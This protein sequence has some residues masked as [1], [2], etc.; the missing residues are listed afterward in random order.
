MPYKKKVFTK[1][2][3]VDGKPYWVRG[4]TDEEAT[5][6][7]K[8]K[9]AAIEAGERVVTGNSTVA[10]WADEWMRTYK[11][12]VVNPALYR[13]M[14]GQIKNYILPLIGKR[15]VRSIKPKDLQAVIN[16]VANQGKSDSLIRAIRDILNGMFREA[17]ANDM[18]KNYPAG[19]LIKTPAGKKKMK[20]RSLTDVERKLLLEVAKTH[21]GGP[22]CLIM[23]YAGLRPAEVA[24]LTWADVDLENRKIR[25]TNAIKADGTVGPPKTEAGIR[26]VPISDEL[27][28]V[29]KPLKGKARDLV[30]T[31]TR[32]ERYNHTSIRRMWDYVRNAM[33]LAA[34]CKSYYNRA[35]PPLVVGDDCQL[36]CLRHTYC[37]DLQAAGVPINVAKEL[38]GHAK[39]ST[40]SEI[41][42][43]SSDAA[44]E[45]AA[46]KINDF[47]KTMV[48]PTV[49][50]GHADAEK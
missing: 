38:M 43:H 6:K 35:V 48:A 5:A 11:A 29:L 28:A 16:D 26:T 50:P 46:S 31:N 24:A 20:R 14:E 33:N 44:F 47:Q 49:A 25:V 1:K 9:K 36:Y 13:D 8:A 17:Y 3:T 40:T 30:V 10:A 41:Y 27:Y 23:L 37:T 15:R 19:K 4:D 42:T 21:R 39:I 2:F 7:A 22:F 34:G 18:I 45:A 32:G 12:N